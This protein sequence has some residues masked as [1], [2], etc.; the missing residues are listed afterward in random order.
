VEVAEHAEGVAVRDSKQPV[1]AILLF[2]S[3]QWR[4]F[5]AAAKAGVF[6]LG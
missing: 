6:D 3:G 1:E 5:V 4:A 2:D